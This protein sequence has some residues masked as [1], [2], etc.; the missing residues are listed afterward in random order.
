MRRHLSAIASHIQIA[1]KQFAHIG[2]VINDQHKRRVF[3]NLY[4]I[5]VSWFIRFGLLNDTCAI[6]RDL[7]RKGRSDIRC[8]DRYD[9]AAQHTAELSCD[10]QPQ[11]GS[12]KFLRSRGIRLSEGVKYLFKLF[13]RHAN[14]LVG[15]V[16]DNKITGV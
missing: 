3:A 1:V 7:H 6:N 4:G 8:A 2:I 16:K 12:A 10:G 13:G 11:T 14:T 9:I 15:D 5:S